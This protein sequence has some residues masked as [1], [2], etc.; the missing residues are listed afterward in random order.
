MMADGDIDVG[1][2]LVS[3]DVSMEA[4]SVCLKPLSVFL[5]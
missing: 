1:V 3:V 5:I 2:F 4:A